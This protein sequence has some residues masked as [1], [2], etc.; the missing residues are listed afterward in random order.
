MIRIIW[1]LLLFSALDDI[2]I[3]KGDCPNQGDCNFEDGSLCDYTNS[4]DSDI[5][6]IV[7]NKNPNQAITGKFVYK[8]R[9]LIYSL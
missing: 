1:L 6:W 3:T 4:I 7:D 5:K 8:Q 9:H 2:R